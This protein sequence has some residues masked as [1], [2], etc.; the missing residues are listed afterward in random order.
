MCRAALADALP[1]I[2]RWRLSALP[3]YLSAQEVDRVIAACDLTTPLGLRDRAIILLLSRLGLRA[4]DVAG[5]MF[6]DLDW[7]TATICVCGKGR[8]ATRLPLPQDVGDA[9]LEYLRGGRPSFPTD[10]IFLR[11]QPPLGPITSATVSS[12]VRRALRTAGVETPCRG[13]HVLR[14]SAAVA[15]LREGASLEKLRLILRH[16][17]PETTMLYAKVDIDVLRTIA[18]PWP[19]VAP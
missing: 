6:A 3:R 14:H 9:I 11:G 7:E 17:D 10:R 1:T 15:M 18:Q 13:A 19:E 2:A 5:L 12:L 16:R 8:R 4:S